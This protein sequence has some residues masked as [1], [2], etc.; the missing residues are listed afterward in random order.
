MALAEQH[1][2]SHT[3][4]SQGRREW[5]KLRK[6][7]LFI[8]EM[9]HLLSPS[10]SGRQK[11]SV[12]SYHKSSTVLMA[13]SLFRREDGYS[14]VEALTLSINIPYPPVEPKIVGHGSRTSPPATPPK[15]LLS[16]SCVELA[17]NV[18]TVTHITGQFSL[19]LNS[20]LHSMVSLDE[21]RARLEYICFPTPPIRGTNDQGSSWDFEWK[22]IVRSEHHT[23]RWV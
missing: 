12:S 6:Q 5:S 14:C 11:G 15:V 4:Q 17:Q 13:S 10:Q 23:K 3:P 9:P 19:T 20:A 16:Q 21:A 7:G 2:Y 1:G 18:P 22:M 8:R